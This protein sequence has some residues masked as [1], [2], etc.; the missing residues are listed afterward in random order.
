MELTRRTR[1]EVIV[2]APLV[3]RVEA[4]LAEAG[5]KGWSVFDGASGSGRHGEWRS[6]GLHPAD[7]KSLVIA[8]TSRERAEAVLERLRALFTDYPGVAA[9]SEVE[10]MRAE[11]F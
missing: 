4:V 7:R 10:V 6:E 2:E 5:V 9:L 3:R 11:R 8:L 1:L